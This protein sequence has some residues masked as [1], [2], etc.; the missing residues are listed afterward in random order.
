MPDMEAIAEAA[1]LRDKILFT[2]GTRDLTM[3]ELATVIFPKAE[4][5]NNDVDYSRLAR[6]VKKLLD[7]GKIT[8]KGL[9]GP[10]HLRA[11]PHVD[12]LP[13]AAPTKRTYTKRDQNGHANGS[14]NG[15]LRAYLVREIRSK[16][17][18]LEALG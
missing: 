17:D 9:R 1:K 2:L 5:T 11:K 16:L 14:A 18:E 15:P 6:Q 8:K 10:L 3:P 7:E 4:H 13:D 12:D